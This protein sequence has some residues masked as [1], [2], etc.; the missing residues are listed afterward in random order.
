LIFSMYPLVKGH[1]LTPLY[2]H[3]ST[4]LGQGAWIGFQ[5]DPNAPQEHP[6]PELVAVSVS[7][8][9]RVEQ[10][11]RSTALLDTV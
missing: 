6:S 1:K 11:S 9:W 5:G 3:M 4:V 2:L 10:G 7:E 8:G